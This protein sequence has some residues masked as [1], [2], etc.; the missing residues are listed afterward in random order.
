[1]MDH[2]LIY[3]S[4]HRNK[5]KITNFHTKENVHYRNNSFSRFPFPW[6]PPWLSLL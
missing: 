5:T 1:M 3:L 6:Y 2:C 4:I